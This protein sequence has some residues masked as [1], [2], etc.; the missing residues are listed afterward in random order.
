MVRCCARACT[1]PRLPVA[2]QSVNQLT[3]SIPSCLSNLTSV[4]LLNLGQN[5]LS[6]APE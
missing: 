3:G 1:E 2:A 6:G 5:Q 4:T